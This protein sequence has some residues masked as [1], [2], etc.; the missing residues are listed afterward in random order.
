MLGNS[1]NIRYTTAGVAGPREES[2]QLKL[3]G[4]IP[5]S[6]DSDVYYGGVAPRERVFSVVLHLACWVT[7]IVF[8]HLLFDKSQGWAKSTLTNGTVTV[9]LDKFSE[10]YALAALVTNWFAFFV[11]FMSAVVF[12]IAQRGKQPTANLTLDG[13]FMSMI[14]AGIRCSFFFTLICALFTVGVQV[15]RGDDWRNWTIISLSMKLYLTSMATH[16]AVNMVA[17]GAKHKP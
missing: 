16:N 17:H 9:A 12:A 13:V 10:P 3:Q 8:D 5:P 6:F 2:A 15:D 7:G 14:T 4:L 1:N 11:V